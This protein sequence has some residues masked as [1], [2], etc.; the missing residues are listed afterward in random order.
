MQITRIYQN[1]KIKIG[2]WYNIVKIKTLRK[3]AIHLTDI[4]LTDLQA[5]SR[6]VALFI[7]DLAAPT[8]HTIDRNN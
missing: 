3:R 7:I 1:L 5:N 6:N 2:L 8:D 4:Q